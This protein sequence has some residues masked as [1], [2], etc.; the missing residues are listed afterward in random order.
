MKKSI[1]SDAIDVILDSYHIT[2]TAHAYTI[3]MIPLK[4]CGIEPSGSSGNEKRPV[5][6]NSNSMQHS[7]PS[8]DRISRK[9]NNRFTRAV[10]VDNEAMVWLS[11]SSG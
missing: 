2:T 11:S 3:S 9:K 1:Q 7:A 6:Y 10:N 8:A 5:V 4:P